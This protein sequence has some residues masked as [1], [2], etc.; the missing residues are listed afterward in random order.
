M[1]FRFRAAIGAAA[2]TLASAL[3]LSAC[4]GSSDTAASTG[5]SGAAPSGGA[6]LVVYSGREEEYM[7]P[8]FD[9]FT[10]ASGTALDVRYGDSPDLALLI[11]EEGDKTPAQ[12]F[13]SQSPSS[14]SYLDQKRLL[15]PLP[16]ATLDRVPTTLRAKD[17]SWVGIAGRQRILVYNTE[18]VTKSELPTSVVDLTKAAYEG[19]VG[20]APSNAS[21]Q[22]FV[23]GLNQLV[24]PQ[25]ASAWLKGMAE[26]GAKAYAKNGAIVEAVARG[27]VP[28]G[29]V[30]HYY[31]TETLAEDPATPIAAHRFPGDDPGSL[32]L[33]ATASVPAPAQGNA[34][35]IALVDFLLSNEGQKLIIEGEGEYPVVEGVTLEEGTPSLTES[36]Y[37]T[38]DL[39]GVTDLKAIS[40]QI[41]ESGLAK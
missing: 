17:G 41:K 28:M 8:V 15:S 9:A 3:V 36:D 33:V 39:T 38:Y 4:G 20:V 22:D 26:N 32:F 24:G 10:K 21:F 1:S 13:I 7:K 31:V 2:A 19:K 5:T 16:A 35:A 11:G 34:D 29:L 14:Q 12:V 37:P 40:D 27:E 25:K 23:A 6:S 18:L 30:N